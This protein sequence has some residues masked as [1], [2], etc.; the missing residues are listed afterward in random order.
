M[1]GVQAI[2]TLFAAQRVGPAT[3]RA[4]P[5]RLALGHPSSGSQTR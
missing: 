3:C 2:S 4:D 1:A 5:Q